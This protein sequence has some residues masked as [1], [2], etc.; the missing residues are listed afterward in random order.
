MF[1][2]KKWVWP[3]LGLGIV[4]LAG[5]WWY[6][7]ET[8]IEGW[9]LEMPVPSPR[10]EPPKYKI[11]RGRF[12]LRVNLPWNFRTT[13]TYL[14]PVDEQGK[15]LPSASDMVF[16][17]PFSGEAWRKPPSRP[18]HFYFAEE[19]GMTIFS[20]SIELGKTYTQEPLDYSN[21]DSGWMEVVM[22]CRELIVRRHG[23]ELRPLLAWGQSAGEAMAGHLALR[24]PDAVDAITGCG[25]GIRVKPTQINHTAWLVLNTWGCPAVPVNRIFEKRMR[26]LGMPCLRAETP[27]LRERKQGVN[28]HTPN[29]EAYELIACFLSDA[30]RLRRENGGRMPPPAQWPVTEVIQGKT[31]QL[32]SAEFARLWR[33]LPHEITAW[34]AAPEAAGNTGIVRSVYPPRDDV[35]R[36]LVVV[37]PLSG[38][39]GLRDS[40][41]ECV[42]P[43]VLA[44]GLTDRFGEAG[45]EDWKRALRDILNEEKWKQYPLEL[46]LGGFQGQLA[47]RAA[48]ELKSERIRRIGCFK[49]EYD[50]PTPEISP[51]K[52]IDGVP[53]Q[54]LWYED[55]DQVIRQKLPPSMERHILNTSLTETAW[56][57]MLA[58]FVEREKLP[59]PS[60]EVGKND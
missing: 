33:Q 8:R 2:K 60:S 26:D 19:L 40:L 55:P 36:L 28:H 4:L 29:Q 24:Y 34:Q 48:L 39:A 14:M 43:G 25:G 52:A 45:V 6:W 32:P 13:V 58:A 18:I 9:T 5:V 47:L 10:Q 30:A 49:L 15:P 7:E 3:A 27:P 17:A 59:D 50:H 16:Y 1:L 42:I 35:K 38:E 51:A 57:N 21:P 44:V 31:Y 11:M 53:A 54:I 41:Y 22:Q 46:A 23:L 12:S 20:F 37:S 56:L